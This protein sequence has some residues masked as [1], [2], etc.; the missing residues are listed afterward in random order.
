MRIYSLKIISD[1]APAGKP[2]KS[3]RAKNHFYVNAHLHIEIKI[4]K[5]DNRQ[6][7]KRERTHDLKYIFLWPSETSDYGKIFC[8]FV[9]MRGIVTD[10]KWNEPRANREKKWNRST[11][12]AREF[13]NFTLRELRKIENERRANA[14]NFWNEQRAN[15]EKSENRSGDEAAKK[16]KRTPKELQKNNFA[17]KQRG[18][19]M[20]RP[21][22]ATH[23]PYMLRYWETHIESGSPTPIFAR[24]KPK[25]STCKC[26]T[27]KSPEMYAHGR[28]GRRYENTA[29]KQTREKMTE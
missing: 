3:E 24:I 23:P 19:D 14:E 29:E 9:W 15:K 7:E 8:S 2:G 13:Y 11:S 4:S 20:S 28:P 5:C 26:A 25:K 6:A 12:E 22:S 21:P 10:W 16:K 27:W 1:N 18:K 17:R